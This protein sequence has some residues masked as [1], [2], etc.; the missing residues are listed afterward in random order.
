MNIIAGNQKIKQY[1]CGVAINKH[2]TNKTMNFWAKSSGCI[3]W[4]AI[5]IIHIGVKAKTV[6]STDRIDLTI[7]DNRFIVYFGV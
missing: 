5:T 7:I 1:I 4:Y 3:I 2:P 6:V